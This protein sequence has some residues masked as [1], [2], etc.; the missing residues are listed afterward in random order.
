[1]FYKW[2]LTHLSLEVDAHHG[3]DSN[4]ENE[5]VIEVERSFFVAVRSRTIRCVRLTQ[6]R[7]RCCLVKHTQVEVVES[8]LTQVL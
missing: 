6:I 8:A 7:P 3:H 1:M 2:L 4:L 5:I